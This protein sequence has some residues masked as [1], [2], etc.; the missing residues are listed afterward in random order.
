[1]HSTAED[2]AQAHRALAARDMNPLKPCGHFV[3][4]REQFPEVGEWRDVGGLED[5]VQL[6][7][8]VNA[9]HDS[10]SPAGTLMIL[11]GDGHMIALPVED[12]GA[13]HFAID[14]LLGE[15]SDS[16]PFS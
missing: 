6:W 4:R 9:D 16:V 15:R 5:A 7:V 2:R 8:G 1:M 13:L 14:M 10:P 3:Y 12:I 11:Q